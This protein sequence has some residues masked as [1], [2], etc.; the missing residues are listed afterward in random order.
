MGESGEKTATT[1]SLAFQIPSIHSLSKI[2]ENHVHVWIPGQREPPCALGWRLATSTSSLHPRGYEELAARH[3]AA[4]QAKR[5]T[6]LRKA[7]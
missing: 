7:T 2:N 3:L 5:A 6:K 1:T 4:L